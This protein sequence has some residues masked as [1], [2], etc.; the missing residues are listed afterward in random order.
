MQQC[1]ANRTFTYGPE[2]LRQIARFLASPGDGQYKPVQMLAANLVISSVVRSPNPRKGN[3]ALAPEVRRALEAASPVQFDLP[4][5]VLPWLKQ[6]ALKG[7]EQEVEVY[8]CLAS[9]DDP[10][11]F[12]LPLDRAANCKELR[13]N[14]SRAILDSLAPGSNHALCAVYPA[15]DNSSQSHCQLFSVQTPLLQYLPDS[16]GTTPAPYFVP[17]NGDGAVILGVLDPSLV[18]YIGQLSDVWMN[19]DKRFDTSAQITDPLEALRQ[20]LGACELDSR[21]QGKH[22]VLLAQ[23]P[24]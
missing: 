13:R 24:Y 18:G 7:G 2:R 5:T 9:A 23:M 15:A 16:P 12:R 21:C 20:L 17:P 14:G 22:K 6:V 11:E 4:S 1:P 10:R 3:E 19:A 8:D